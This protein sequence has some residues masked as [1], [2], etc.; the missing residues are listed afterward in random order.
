MFRLNCMKSIRPFFILKA[1]LSRLLASQ[2]PISDIERRVAGRPSH[3]RPLKLFL[4]AIGTSV[5]ALTLT[6][7]Y[8]TLSRNNNWRLDIMALTLALRFDL[9]LIDS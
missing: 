3:A 7:L 8:S 5:C 4:S 6:P 2:R 9:L 1:N